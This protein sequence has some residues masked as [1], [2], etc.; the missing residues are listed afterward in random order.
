MGGWVDV[1]MCGWVVGWVDRHTGACA[2][3]RAWVCALAR[4][5]AHGDAH[6]YGQWVRAVHRQCIGS[7]SAEHRQ[8]IGSRPHGYSTFGLRRRRTATWSG[9]HSSASCN[10]RSSTSSWRASREAARLG[11]W[12]R[13]GSWPLSRAR[14]P[15]HPPRATDACV[16]LIPRMRRARPSA[17]NPHFAVRVSVPEI[18]PSLITVVKPDC[19][20]RVM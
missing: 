3:G 20:T 2:C 14:A 10:G 19:R 16:L 4:G 1:W 7:A 18:V 8:S 13:H 15:P 12:G 5:R 9:A 6:G 11:P 17:T